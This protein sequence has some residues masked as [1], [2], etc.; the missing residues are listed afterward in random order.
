MTTSQTRLVFLDNLRY[1]L[2]LLVV[3]LHVSISYS[4]GLP[5]WYIVDSNKSPFFD[6]LIIV[7]DSFLMPGLFFMAGYFALSSLQR[8]KTAGAF[9]VAKLKRL[10]IPWFLSV[11]LLVPI[12]PYFYH[13]TRAATPLSFGT[14]W[15]GFVKSVGNFKLTLVEPSNLTHNANLMN[16]FGHHH[17]WFISLLLFF[18][19]GFALLYQLKA[20]FSTPTS[21]NH[22]SKIQSIWVVLL[23]VGII[24]SLS[25]IVINYFIF[26]FAWVSI[27][28][29]LL[30][31]PVRLPLYLGLFGLG[32]YAYSKNWLTQH[33]L[34]GSLL[35]W[36]IA[37][38][39][40][41]FI[42]FGIIAKI[43]A[44]ISNDAT[45]PI[46]FWLIAT[47]GT[48]RTF[49]GLAWLV[50]LLSLT[51]RYWNR[52]TKSDQ[53]L[54]A[55]S[56]YIYIIHL[57]IVVIFQYL[58]LAVNISIFVKFS[59]IVCLSILLSYGISHFLRSIQ[60]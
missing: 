50:L 45:S 40:L 49:L 27:Y 58:F 12:M 22:N 36:F 5:W 16:E 26:S 29:V 31:Q 38:L 51:Q 25:V 11:F 1:L 46:P 35:M 14:F 60:N 9:I 59:L 23:I 19:I 56:Y 17:L 18:F 30:F 4:N 37:C 44:I 33:R 54:A 53:N 7:F 28:N 57:P 55:S 21:H 3:V 32:I 43:L 47:H 34:P 2:V 8:K 20:Q 24:I 39:V 42:L 52:P 48:V 10:G 41:T 13:Y 15:L 6:L